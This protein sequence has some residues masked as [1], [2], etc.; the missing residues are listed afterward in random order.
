ME[1]IDLL[2]GAYGHGDHTE[3]YVEKYLS[4]L[5]EKCDLTDVNV[6]CVERNHRPITETLRAKITGMGFQVRTCPNL[7]SNS[8]RE[9]VSL[10]TDWMVENCSTSPWFVVS[11]YDVEFNGDYLKFVR[12]NAITADMVGRHHDGIMAVHRVVYKACR[13]G[14]CGLDNMRIH[15]NYHGELEILPANSMRAT[16]QMDRVLSLD[17]GELLELRVVTL[18]LRHIL[19]SHPE[20]GLGKSVLF[21]H[22]RNGSEH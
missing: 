20:H 21:T 13:V 18:G 9:D 16:G 7:P 14:F 11:H 5:C 3:T 1:Q 8:C 19:H 2:I 6:F 12:D 10:Y 15:H 22:F 4:S 17:V